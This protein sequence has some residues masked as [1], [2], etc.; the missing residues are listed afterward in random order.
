M[1][2]AQ[3]VSDVTRFRQCLL[4]AAAAEGAAQ[5]QALTEAVAAYGEA[6]EFLA[7]FY[8]DWVLAERQTLQNELLA[9]LASLTTWYAEAE[10][11]P[12][13]LSTAERAVAVDPLLEESHQALI[14]LLAQSGQAAAAR[15]QYDALAR[16]LA[17]ELNAEPSPA[18]RALM[19]Q[20]RQ[21]A[22]ASP[23]PSLTPP[24]PTALLRVAPLP[25]PLTTFHGR[26]A[27]VAELTAFLSDPVTRLVTLL[28]TGG[29]GKTRLALEV[30]RAAPLAAFV[31][32]ADLAEPGRLAEAIAAALTPVRESPPL[33]RIVSALTTSPDAPPFLLVLD[34]A[35]HLAEAV[36]A[37]AA[38][39]LAQVPRLRVLVT[40]Q[41]VLGIG[42][43]R[44]MTLPPLETPGDPEASPSV[45]LFLD[46][47]RVVRQGFPTDAASLAEVAQIC[48]R[49]E[50]LPLAIELCA[51]WAQTLGTRQ[52]LELLDRRF[53]L[54]VSRRTDIATRHRTLRAAIEYSYIQ[55]S[56]PMQDFLVR[57][58]VFRG[59]WTLSA[60]AEVCAG[61]SVTEALPLLAQ[62]RT[63]SLIV[64]DEAR[65]GAGMRY[66]MLESLRDFAG[67]QRTL[68]QA[69][70]HAASHAAYFA[71]FVEDTVARTQGEESILWTARLEDERENIR[72]A[73]E[74]FTVQGEMEAAWILTAAIAPAWNTHGHAREAR[75]WTERV[76]AMKTGDLPDTRRLR[77][78]LLTAQGEALRLLSDFALA[79]DSFTQ[80][81]ILWRELEDQSGTTECV[82]LLGITA[83][84]NSDFERAEALLTEA[85]TPA[86]ALGDLTLL[87]QVLNDLGR[88][89]M[90][91]QYWPTA[92]AR[93]SEGLTLRRRLGDMRL[94]C[95]SL[96]NVALVNRY[97]RSYGAARVLLQ[98]AAAIQRRH[99]AVWF[100]STDLNLATVERLDG[101][102]AESLRL[103]G[104]AQRKA[105]A[106]GE[107]RV[108]AWCVKEMGH[109]AVAVKHYALGLRLLSCAEIMR[110]SIEM[111]FKPLGPE[112]IARDRWVCEQA[113]GEAE[114]AASWLLG[115][116]A[117]PE[118][119]F[120][121]A[122]TVLVKQIFQEN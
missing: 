101:C 56:R 81:L 118:S 11:W 102:H 8:E 88:I 10:D 39:L 45:R 38:A 14:R 69:R 121:E 94:M 108:T 4:Q 13:A 114:A 25:V 120:A 67:E 62:M 51:G 91:A 59:G 19:A 6:G 77:A 90:A 40:S 78:R 23:F 111:S 86:R 12:R 99:G 43:E 41:R 117:A 92:L 95:A 3:I 18:T 63:H 119:L 32:L 84:L 87:A 27:A 83:M 36:G 64:A 65:A 44:E 29:I 103:L 24:A 98:E 50:G 107:R 116:S 22:D 60:A 71:R 61:G 110:V 53:E 35:E 75:E 52:M 74:H 17:R 76:L 5:A 89:A 47:A 93:F 2:V 97:Q 82:A 115:T 113:L 33:P 122:E 48:E 104:T 26:E 31:P 58:S 100:S 7:G 28:G 106:H 1:D 34:N 20:V 80:A 46:R 72:T 9:A 49:L 37:V 109:L 73:L 85:L 16:L 30:A 105:Q 79:T 96:G 55:L 68:G 42:G 57:L 66:A 21:A 54:L 112:D 70:Q 15:R